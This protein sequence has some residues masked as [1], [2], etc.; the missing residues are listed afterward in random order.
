VLMTM[1]Q[2]EHW[3]GVPGGIATLLWSEPKWIT[4]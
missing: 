2:V 3:C 1:K 4:V